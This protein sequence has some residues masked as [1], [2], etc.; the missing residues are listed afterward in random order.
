[1][2]VLIALTL[3]YSL[4]LQI[5]GLLPPQCQGGH[6]A[7]S[8]YVHTVKSPFLS[9]YAELNLASRADLCDLFNRC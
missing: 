1:M 6:L 5:A 8:V 4:T 9:A 3:S 7:R 2:F